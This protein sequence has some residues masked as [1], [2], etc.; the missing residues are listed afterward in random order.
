MSRF[1][2]ILFLFA[3]LLVA[4]DA[5][6]AAAPVT[7]PQKPLVLAPNESLPGYTEGES[8]GAPVS[9]FVHLRGQRI[10]HLR[11]IGLVTGLANTG[12]NQ[13]ALFTIQLVL[14]TLKKQGITLPSN[15]MTS[16]LMIMANDLATVTVT[17]DMPS[18]VRQGDRLDVNVAAMGNASSLQGGTLLMTPLVGTDGDVYAVAQGPV[19]IAGYF[20][21]SNG[22]SVSTNF[23]TSGQIAGGATVERELNDNFPDNGPLELDL[24]DPD[25]ALA[26]QVA[27]GIGGN[28]RQVSAVVRS[29][30]TVE[31]TLPPWMAASSFV[32]SLRD[33][34]IR[35]PQSNR[36]V[37]NEKTGTVVVGG[38][39]TIGKSA[40]S[41]GDYTITIAPE[42]QVS[43][44][45]P[46]GAGRTVAQRTARIG[47][48]Q[49]KSRFFMTPQGA[50]VEQVAATLSAVGVKPTDTAAIFQAFK[51]AGV[52]YGELIV[53]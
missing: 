39:V 12:D 37:V 4:V 3:C 26:E 51:Q 52:L 49:E 46:F 13:M 24:N 11:G 50:S 9:D 42:L 53:R 47:V 18:S 8:G 34:Y 17:A 6:R 1:A 33:V 40:V 35:P 48:N 32:A 16:P 19:S 5:A 29:P 20:A 21:G 41:Y 28:I 2:T 31:V 14:N 15:L 36:V 22:A 25:P 23:Q 44:P 38:D 27:R 30:D 7:A 10:N 45:N 43:Q